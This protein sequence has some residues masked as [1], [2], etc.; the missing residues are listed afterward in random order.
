MI[1]FKD[2]ELQHPQTKMIN[3]IHLNIDNI[4]QA[5]QIKL[6]DKIANVQD[7]IANPPTAWSLDRR[8]EY[9]AWTAQVVAG[10]RGTNPALEALYD[11]TL[12]QGWQ[13]LGQPPTR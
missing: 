5:R 10:C 2:S 9:L 4:H 7:I 12:A 6:A 8:Q 3:F 11:Q 13:A 1:D